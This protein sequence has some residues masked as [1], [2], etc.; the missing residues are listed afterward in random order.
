MAGQTGG[1]EAGSNLASSET[2]AAGEWSA[3]VDL[4]QIELTLLPVSDDPERVCYETQAKLL[5]I[6]ESL[7]EQRVRVI[8]VWAHPSGDTHLG[9]F[10]ITLAPGAIPAIAAVA[11]AWIRTRSGR[12]VRLRLDEV[13][14]EASTAEA[15]DDLLKLAS[16]LQVRTQSEAAQ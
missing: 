6:Q 13:E 8:T 2:S 4:D 15:L 5:A 1:T 7:W 9:Q 14:T 3:A 16:A 11:G 12:G 10:I